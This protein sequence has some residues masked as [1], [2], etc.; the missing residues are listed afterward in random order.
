MP[1]VSSEDTRYP[2][3]TNNPLPQDTTGILR[4]PRFPQE[5]AG[6][7][8]IRCPRTPRY[9]PGGVGTPCILRTPPR[10]LGHGVPR[11]YRPLSWGYVPV[12]SLRM[13]SVSHDANLRFQTGRA[14]TTH[15]PPARR[16]RA[17][18]PAPAASA[19]RPPS[20]T[21]QCAMDSNCPAPSACVGTSYPPGGKNETKLEPAP[22]PWQPA[23]S[24]S[25]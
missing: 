25:K 17:P 24:T 2:Q 16:P 13:P 1:S 18:P 7:L 14:A 19:P 12:S 22:R 23:R 6:I 20:R 5:T 11:I 15:P 8:R 10:V 3:D 9:P 21:L 4:I